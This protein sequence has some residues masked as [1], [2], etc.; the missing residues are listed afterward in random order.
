MKKNKCIINKDFDK[1]VYPLFNDGATS[2][3]CIAEKYIKIHT[4]KHFGKS[5]IIHA[6]I[7]KSQ[8]P[9]ERDSN[10]NIIPSTNDDFEPS[11]YIKESIDTMLLGKICFTE[12]RFSAQTPPEMQDIGKLLNKMY[13]RI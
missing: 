13:G 8:A 10:Y 12:G 1:I 6:F 7:L 9:V 3:L 4:A 11:C 5:V 2:P